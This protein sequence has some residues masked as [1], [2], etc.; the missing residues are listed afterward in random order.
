MALQLKCG[1]DCRQLAV[2]CWTSLLIYRT[3][4]PQE[5][6]RHRMGIAEPGRELHLVAEG[7]RIQLPAGQNGTYQNQTVSQCRLRSVRQCWLIALCLSPSWQCASTG[8]SN[9][10]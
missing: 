1:G 8:Q 5:A 3:L 6:A 9:N 4:V 10:A 7:Q 2:S